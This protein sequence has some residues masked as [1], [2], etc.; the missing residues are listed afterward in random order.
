MM[1]LMMSSLISFQI[2]QS[3]NS[4]G[5]SQGRNPL[6]QIEMEETTGKSG[7]Q[8]SVFGDAPED[9]SPEMEG[10]SLGEGSSDEKWRNLF[11]KCPEAREIILGRIE[12][13]SALACRLV[14]REWRETVNRYKKLWGKVKEVFSIAVD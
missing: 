3:E 14:C 10:L 13:E 7:R 2:I 12:L 4:E 6:Q 5:A 1:V 11:T 9:R 8:L